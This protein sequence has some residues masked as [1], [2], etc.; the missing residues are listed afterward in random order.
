VQP[1]PVVDRLD[2]AADPLSC[3]FGVSVGAP[4]DLLLF[5]CFHEAFGLG[6]VVRVADPL[7]ASST[8]AR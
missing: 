3:V 2:E 7:W 5:E 1:L 6:V 8:M 4:V